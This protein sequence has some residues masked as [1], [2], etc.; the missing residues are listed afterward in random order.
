MIIKQGQIFNH[1]DYGIVKFIEVEYYHWDY[2][3]KLE[4]LGTHDTYYP[5]VEAMLELGYEIID[6]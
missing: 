2:T 3:V 5:K 4:G 6:K 1:P